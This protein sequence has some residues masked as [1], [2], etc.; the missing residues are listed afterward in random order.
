MLQRESPG[1]I[2]K[3]KNGYE[4]SIYSCIAE[5]AVILQSVN[6]LKAA[7]P[8]MGVEFFNILSERIVK[9]GF[10]NERL[11]DAVNYVIDNFHYKE[12][13]V[14]DIIKF[15]KRV[16]LY[17]YDEVTCLVTEGKASFDDFK[18]VKVDG[19]IFRVR[20]K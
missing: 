10:S 11:Q 6:R 1:R 18:I 14:S 7:F 12:L 20:K 8:K 4:M 3:A 16:K 19:K 13:N 17:T 9:N 5:P 2:I 15:D